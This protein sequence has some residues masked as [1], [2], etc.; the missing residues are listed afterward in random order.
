MRNLDQDSN[1]LGGQFEFYGRRMFL[2]GE[3]LGFLQVLK[4][5]TLVAY[6]LKNF[7]VFQIRMTIDLLPIQPQMAAILDLFFSE[8]LNVINSFRNECS[9]KNHVKMRYYIK[10]YVK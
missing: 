6:R 7:Y 9:I 2:S 5:D 8:T 10:I 4:E 3:T 1:L